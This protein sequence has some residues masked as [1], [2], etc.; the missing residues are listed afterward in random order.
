MGTDGSFGAGSFLRQLAFREDL[1]RGV[2]IS[3]L[4]ALILAGCGGAAQSS[5]RP[6][7]AASPSAAPS[8]APSPTES[9]SPSP[10]PA[11]TDSAGAPPAAA[12]PAATPIAGFSACPGGGPTSGEPPAGDNGPR[13]A[14]FAAEILYPAG[15]ATCHPAGGGTYAGTS[16]CPLYP[17]LAQR[18]DQHPLSGPTGGGADALCRCQ[19]TYQTVTYAVAGPAQD[20]PTTYTVRVTLIFGPTSHEALDVIVQGVQSG[21]LVSDVQC[22]GGGPPTSILEAPTAA[23]R[24]LRC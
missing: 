18:L 6:K 9:P 4:C 16:N 19:N 2:V 21:S 3:G 11:P 12:I 22:A 5:P 10:T 23:N 8:V 13:G 1:M 15:G 20:A 14:C 7:A 24:Y 17:R